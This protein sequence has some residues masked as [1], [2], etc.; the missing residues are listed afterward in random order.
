[1]GFTL[2]IDHVQSNSDVLVDWSAEPK[3]ALRQ[4]HGD[5]K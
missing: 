3:G 5:L 2:P 1:M 4:G